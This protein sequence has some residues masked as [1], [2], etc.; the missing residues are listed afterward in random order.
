[1]KNLIQIRKQLRERFADSISLK[2]SEMATN[3]V[4]QEFLERAMQI[5]ESNLANEQF[6]ID[7]LAQ[8]IGMSRPNL[9]RKLRAL[10]NQSTNQVIQSARLHR[11]TD[12]LKQDAGTVSEIAFQTGFSSTAYFVKCF[13]D[14]YGHTPGSLLKKE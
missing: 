4:D 3:S 2:P 13:K 5:I 8:E 1:V 14:Q 7:R 10:L 12:L 9:N 11:A 6:N